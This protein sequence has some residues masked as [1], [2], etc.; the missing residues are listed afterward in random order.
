VRKVCKPYGIPV[1]LQTGLTSSAITVPKKLSIDPG[2]TAAGA[3]EAVCRVAGLLAISDGRGGLVLTRA[4]TAR[5]TDSLLEGANV[6]SARARYD[7]TQRFRRVIVLGTKAGT[8]EESG[9]VVINTRGQAEDLN[10][11]AQRVTIVRPESSVNAAQAKTRA[12][13]EVAIRAARGDTYSATV[14]GWTQSNGAL[15][16]LNSLVHLRS[17]TLEVDE[18][19]LVSGLT[20]TRSRDGGTTTSMD[21]RHAGA[22]APMPQVP[23]R[24]GSGS[25]A[26]LR[27]GV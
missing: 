4:G 15:W 24:A 17:P 16:P 2:D 18:D 13:W 22:F 5:C 19:L 1:A 7:R 21:L 14:Q 12:Q 11:P 6:L 8:D 23:V 20:L 27:G 10:S 25:Y 26:E 9:T 3:I